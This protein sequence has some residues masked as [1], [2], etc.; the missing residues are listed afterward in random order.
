M[1][2]YYKV[3]TVGLVSLFLLS[4]ISSFQINPFSLNS[5]LSDKHD[6][7]QL[8]DQESTTISNNLNCWTILIYMSADNNLEKFAIKDIQEML[9][10]SI[11]VDSC[12]RF[13]LQIDRS[14]SSNTSLG[15]SNQPLPGESIVYSSTRRY[16]ISNGT[17]LQVVSSNSSLGNNDMGNKQ[18]FQSFLSW[19]MTNYPANHTVLIM[20]GYGSGISQ[21]AYDETNQ[22]SLR[23]AD[24]HDAIQ[25]VENTTKKKIDI[26]GFDSSSMA[27]INTLFALQ[28]VTHYIIASETLEPGQSWDYEQIFDIFKGSTLS[29]LTPDSWSRSVVRSYNY[30]FRSINLAS[31]GL[32]VYNT[33]YIPYLIQT[34]RDLGS[35]L[36]SQFQSFNSS[37]IF[38]LTQALES[39][40]NDTSTVSF[41]QI[42]L[43]DFL[44]LFQQYRSNPQLLNLTTA[45]STA[46][47][48][49]INDFYSGSLLPH[50]HGLSIFFPFYQNLISNR[51]YYQNDNVFRSTNW[52]EFLQSYFSIISDPTYSTFKE[53]NPIQ[54]LSTKSISLHV[55]ASQQFSQ[56]NLLLN[57]LVSGPIWFNFTIISSL[58]MPHGGNVLIYEQQTGGRLSISPDIIINV[59]AFN[60]SFSGS[61]KYEFRHIGLVYLRISFIPADSQSTYGSSPYLTF[62]KT[63]Y[64]PNNSSEILPVNLGSFKSTFISPEP[65]ILNFSL[66]NIDIQDY[67]GGLLKILLS[68]QST[69]TF[70]LVK[71]VSISSIPHLHLAN[72]SISFPSITQ[73]GSYQFMLI[74]DNT[75]IFSS[76]SYLSL[77]L[78][79]QFKI[80]TAIQSLSAKALFNGSPSY[81]FNQ[82]F[83]FDASTSTPTIMFSTSSNPGSLGDIAFTFSVK[84]QL[85]T[86]Y[87]ENCIVVIVQLFLLFPQLSVRFLLVLFTP[88]Q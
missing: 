57:S 48:Y 54:V 50:L 66:A 17:I 72:Y 6:S 61:F 12:V 29:Y 36:L 20:W 11:T 42:D 46:L 59:P 38:S 74:L 19:G 14:K 43:L 33:L 25:N 60:K 53:N 37:Q 51:T 22:S 16:E 79:N 68:N 24:M 2:S 73:S 52:F 21:L 63:F 67:P 9:L 86:L 3:L 7:N 35:A 44:T 18:I 88:F 84:D 13:I 87:S 15:Y 71:T 78:P 27:S 83:D 64:I 58:N 30:Y 23:L 4:S 1:K 40:R 76:F 47:Q 70:Y 62:S 28:D 32:G 69:N 26:I 31:V 80:I 82:F 77:F 56:S 10:G 5:N 45:V 55:I 8:N 41:N 85:N 34:L 49:V 81:K 65:V 75:T 39:A